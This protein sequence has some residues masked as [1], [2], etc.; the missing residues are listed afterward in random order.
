[1]AAR[2][3]DAVII[4]GGHNGLVAAAYLSRAGQRV[5]LLERLAQ[6][7]GAAVSARLTPDVRDILTVEGSVGSRDGVGG[8]APARVEEQRTEL[9]ARAQSAAHALGL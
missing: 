6:V 5:L 9:I 1:M 2:E 3:F 7:G 8:T 4:G